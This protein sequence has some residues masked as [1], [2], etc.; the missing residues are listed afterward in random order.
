MRREKQDAPETEAGPE[1]C[2]P[3]ME[4]ETLA[5]AQEADF[6]VIALFSVQR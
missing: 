4:T 6:T 3:G 1:D 5:M 2:R